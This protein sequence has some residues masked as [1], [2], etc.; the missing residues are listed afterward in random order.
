M[1]HF[2]PSKD[3][4]GALE[5]ADLFVTEIFRR[6]GLPENF[7]S[8]RDPRF[9]S[10]FFSAICKHLGIKQ[11]MSTAFHPQTDGQTERANR[12][13][14]EMLRHYVGPSQDDWDLNNATKA[15]HFTSIMAV[16]QEGLPLL[17]WILTFQQSTNLLQALTKHFR[18]QRTA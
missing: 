2:A 4:I 10:N 8:D 3:T 13:L 11:A 7:V 1:V 15:H 12:T 5:F 17:L 14:E 9:T 6:H 16:T 18:E